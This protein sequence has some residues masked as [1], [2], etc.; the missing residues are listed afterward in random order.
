M[1]TFPP[2]LFSAAVLFILAST[3][4]ALAQASSQCI[5][6]R[7][8]Q[9]CPSFQ[10]AFINPTNLSNAWPWF[11]AVTD[12]HSFDEQFERYF[13]DE[14]RFHKTK[15]NDQLQCNTTNAERTTLQWQKTI[16]CSQFSQISYSAQC[17][18]QNAAV[19][20]MVCQQ[21]CI[22]YAE[23]ERDI[24]QN[25]RICED[26]SDLTRWQNRTRYDTLEKDYMDCTDWTSLATT[27]VRSCVLG[28]Q[29]EGNCG[30]GGFSNQLCEYCDPSGNRTVSSC[31]YNENTDLSGCAEFGY[32]LAAT[33]RPTQSVG[34]GIGSPTSTYGSTPSSTS[35]SYTATGSPFPTGTRTSSHLP[36]STGSGGGTTSGQNSGQSA[37]SSSSSLSTGQLAGIIVG[38]ILAA[39]VLGAIVALLFFKCCRRDRN[40]PE[41]SRNLVYGGAAQGSHTGEKPWI[42]SDA[43]TARSDGGSP[44]M[45]G[46]GAGGDGVKFGAAG[47]G[48]MAAGGA[49]IAAT[50][51]A[52]KGRESED[53]RPASAMSGGSG[54]DGRGVSIPA[55]KDQYSSHDIC[56][57]E[58]V[59]AIY[60]YNA[61]LND[62]ISLQPDDVITVQ[63]LYDDGWALGKTESGTEGAFPLV[64]VT[65]TKGGTSSG[66]GERLGTSN[67]G[68]T[69]G[70]EGHLTSS[71]DEAVTADEGGLT[72]DTTGTRQ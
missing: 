27:N 62:E 5:S 44:P 64:C 51:A 1:R 41:A 42:L 6:L 17:N 45:L 24:V 19:P 63:R 52:E 49:T 12:V 43:G 20:I 60:P 65:S 56:P 31:C 18:S 11:S 37:S 30:W 48:L 23:T 14:N 54:G 57:G 28:D 15:F 16:Y 68:M 50:A 26:D 46:S 36:A 58:T 32:P 22:E 59:V 61:T 33:I 70:N 10:D 21:T 71:V 8:S 72:S 35:S 47:A 66:S 4:S 40:D 69:S 34:T 2:G 38:C 53:I 7:G 25:P 39:L 29:N 13:N 67:S 9:Q 55:I 3:D